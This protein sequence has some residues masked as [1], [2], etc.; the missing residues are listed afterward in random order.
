MY[1][2]QASFRIAVDLA[3]GEAHFMYTMGPLF[4]RGYSLKIEFVGDT[5]YLG[6]EIMT[7][8]S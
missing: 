7:M 4:G 2:S 6:E 1:Y 5:P 3:K 8:I